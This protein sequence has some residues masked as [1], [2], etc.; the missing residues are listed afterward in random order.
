MHLDHCEEVLKPGLASTDIRQRSTWQQTTFASRAVTDM[1]RSGAV[2][3]QVLREGP[4][5]DMLSRSLF[6]PEL[7]HLFL[8]KSRSYARVPPNRKRHRYLPDPADQMK[9]SLSVGVT[10]YYTMVVC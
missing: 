4:C 6:R 10:K 1:E 5:K 8:R 9:Y 2:V 3:Y 7:H